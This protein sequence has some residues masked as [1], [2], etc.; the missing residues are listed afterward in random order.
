V[1]TANSEVPLHRWIFGQYNRLLPAKVSC[2][3]LANLLPRTGNGIDIVEASS[4]IT[5]EIATLGNYLQWLDKKYGLGRDQSLVTAFP[6]SGT[7]IEKSLQRYSSQFVGNINKNGQLTGLLT[8]YKLVNRL[9]S[10]GSRIELTEVGW[11]FAQLQNPVLDDGPAS[12]Q[13][14]LSSEEISLLV[15]HIAEA[16][17]AEAF[18]FRMII[19]A[20]KSG[21][22]TP[23][24]LD[25]YLHEH[26]AASD[27]REFR[28]SFLSSQRS[29]AVSRMTDLGLV[30][31]KREGVR[32]YYQ[33]TDRG[34]EFV[35]HTPLTEGRASE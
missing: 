23:E 20:I 7:G 13:E 34:I 32:V 5:G 26:V 6:T 3:G 35:S 27:S 11:K 19:K 2:R 21:A 4:V 33:A 15:I 10:R 24:S 30:E 25:L 1:W 16:V 14:K 8:D 28:S 29:G 31:R 17:P 9:G 18:A 12:P 22:A